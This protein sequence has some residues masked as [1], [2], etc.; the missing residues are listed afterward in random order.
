M[1]N[2]EFYK[3]GK[4]YQIVDNT[5]DNIYVGSTCKKLCQRLA[6]HRTDY[7]KYLEGK[8]HYV[9]SYE[10][11]K[12]S[13]YKI[14]LL[15]EFPCENIEQ[16]RKREG[17]YIQTLKCVNKQIAG[18]TYKE[19]IQD[20]KEHITERHKKYYEANKE[21]RKKKEERRKKKEERKKKKLGRSQQISHTS[22]FGMYRSHPHI[23]TSVN[24]HATS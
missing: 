4:I 11:L 21:R 8:Y 5:N 17:Y 1:V 18:R 23:Y 6:Q 15:E 20:N 7:N 16:L 2:T 12:N 19:Y 22:Q 13:D 3:N 14:L 9:S 24:T 10:I